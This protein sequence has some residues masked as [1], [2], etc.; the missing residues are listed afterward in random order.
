MLGLGLG[1]LGQ[2]WGWG[3]GWGWGQGRK[4][5]ELGGRHLAVA[6]LERGVDLLDR[7][8]WKL[9]VRLAKA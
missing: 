6:R 8:L 3:W 1:C 7:A 2:C 4:L 9:G 5:P